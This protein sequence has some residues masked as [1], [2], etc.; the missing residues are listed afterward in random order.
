MSDEDRARAHFK[1][2]VDGTWRCDE[3]RATVADASGHHN[4]M[5]EG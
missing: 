5:L 3:G 4:H 1:F 2:I